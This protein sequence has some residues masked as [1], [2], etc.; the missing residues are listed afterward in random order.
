[1]NKNI[2][3]VAISIITMMTIEIGATGNPIALANIYNNTSQTVTISNYNDGSNA[4]IATIGAYA[5]YDDAAITLSTT[6][7]PWQIKIAGPTIASVQFSPTESPAEAG[8]KEYIINYNSGY[9]I[10]FYTP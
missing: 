1:M 3:L 4:T 10:G 2:I 9:S 5:T 6:E 8:Y 7:L